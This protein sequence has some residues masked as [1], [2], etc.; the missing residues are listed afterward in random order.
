MYPDNIPQRAGCKELFC[1]GIRDYPHSEIS[2]LLR[3]AS[4]EIKSFF[5][6][7]LEPEVLTQRFSGP[8]GN[9]L[10]QGVMKKIYPEESMNRNGT[11]KTIVNSGDYR[12]GI[13]VETCV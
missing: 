6:E 3:K 2:S 13:V 5:V 1:T 8:D 10:C 11:W 12:Q 9:T 4:L 7:D